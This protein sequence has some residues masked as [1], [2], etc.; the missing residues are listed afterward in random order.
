[1]RSAE[2]LLQVSDLHQGFAGRPVL[3]A[4]NLAVPR[5]S[6]VSVFGR[7]GAG[8]SVF[9]KCVAG[10]LTPDRGRISFNGAAP[11]VVG[12]KRNNLSGRIG[13]VFQG[14]ALLDSLTALENV[15]LPLAQTTHLASGEIEVRA[16]R[17]LDRLGLIV[18]RDH[19]PNQLS[20]GMQK[21][22]AL[23]RALVSEPEL[24]LFDE[25]TA[26]LDPH[27]RNAVFAMIAQYRRAFGFTALIVTHD[28]VEAL[29]ISD[30]VALLG[31]GS[32]CFEGTS[33][34]FRHSSQPE[35]IA[36]RES[37]GNLT[38]QIARIDRGEP[39]SAEDAL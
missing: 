5:G 11:E 29:E 22:V 39:A 20:G 3:A 37:L 17:A 7:S 30:R 8:K 9:L 26:G 16:L 32:F 21:R 34:E 35:V 23:A 10:L 4:V 36:M 27:S 31:Q 33:A 14:N 15:V 1:M 28:V 18:F 13:Y 6:V 38:A 12:R 25:P 19:F 24:L 2:L